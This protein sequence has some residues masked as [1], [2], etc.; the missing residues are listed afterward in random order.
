MTR[1]ELTEI[2]TSLAL[3]KPIFQTETEFQGEL[4]H[5]LEL[6]GYTVSQEVRMNIAVNG[7]IVPIE[8]D[9]VVKQREIKTALELK[10]IAHIASINHGGSIY[11]FKSNGGEPNMYR[12][13]VLK[14]LNRV[15]RLVAESKVT[16]GYSITISNDSRAWERDTLDD[17]IAGSAFSLHQNRTLN[18][19]AALNWSRPMTANSVTPGGMPPH[20]PLRVPRTQVIQWE[21]YSHF[22]ASNGIFKYLILQG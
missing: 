7:H 4:A 19:G 14:D 5:R 9:I 2:I 13:N 10:L 12:F 17:G 18:E 11:N 16:R 1:A 21:Q 20:V 8:V 22:P 15:G 6:A 3:E